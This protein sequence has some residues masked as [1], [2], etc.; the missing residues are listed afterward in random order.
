MKRAQSV[1][2]YLIIMTFITLAIIWSATNFLMPSV[3]RV[4]GGG[5]AGF[6]NEAADK[7]NID[8]KRGEGHTVTIPSYPEDSPSEAEVP[9]SGKGA[10]FRILRP[11]RNLHEV[12][13]CRLDQATQGHLL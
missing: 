10:G 11:S 4:Y 12:R 2:E 1:L 3:E 13:I 7:R 9:G 8:H 5:Y 6:E